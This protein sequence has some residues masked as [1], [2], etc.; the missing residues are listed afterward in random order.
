VIRS[1]RW[2]V[3]L[4]V[5]M[6]GL[7]AILSSCGNS[8]PYSGTWKAAPTSHNG[9]FT[10]VIHKANPPWWSISMGTKDFPARFYAADINGELQT[11]NAAMTLKRSGDKLEWTSDPGAQPTVFTRQ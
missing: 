8:D 7:V 10:F 9:A 2:S 1:I 3:A 11:G 6:V 4:V 5:V